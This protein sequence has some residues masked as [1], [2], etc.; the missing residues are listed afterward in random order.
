MNKKMVFFMVGRIILLEAVLLLLPTI[1]SAIYK[2]KCITSFLITI[3]LAAILGFLLILLNKPKDRTIFAKEGFVIVALAWISLSAIGALPFVLSGEIPSYHDAFFET[4]SG[5]TT[6]GASIL[7]QV[8]GLSK[9]ILFWRSFTHWIGGMGILV[10]VMALVPTDT[11]RSMHIIKAEMPGPIIGKLVPKMSAT[12]K[13]LYLIYIAMT[14]LEIILLLAGDMSFYES[15]LHAFG[16]AGTGGFG[17]KNDSIAGYSS[18]IQW[19]ITIFMLLFGVNFNIYYLILIRKVRSALK[20]E[21]LITYLAI[22]LVSVG[23][24]TANIY[25]TCSSFSQALRDSAFQVASIISTTGYSTVDF[26]LWPSLSKGVLFILMFFGGCAGST[27]GGLKLSRIMLLFK[28]IRSNLKHMLHSRSV[29]SIHYEGKKTDA[30]TVSA[31]CIYFALYSLC[32][33]VIFLLLSF[34]PFDMETTISATTA[35]F[36]N[37]GPGFSAVG[38]TCNYSIYSV[39]SKYI[40]S[41]AMLLGRLELYPIILLF[42]PSVWIK[43]RKISNY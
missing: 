21:E 1:C 23:I 8:E 33:L 14:V 17:V 12:A 38:P 18:Y 11:G 7:P 37:V 10:L 32:F 24:I 27:A 2:E 15:V 29:E 41:A 4:V 35:C 22:V 9:G 5:F 20:S 34:E 25:N 26:N 16:T 42:S 39:F 28:T 31:V 40:L 30:S 36:N 19:I 3:G 6:T 13:I 43:T